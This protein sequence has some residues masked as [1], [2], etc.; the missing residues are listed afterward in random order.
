MPICDE[1]IFFSHSTCSPSVPADM[2]FGS[3]RISHLQFSSRIDSPREA[4]A[5][6]QSPASEVCRDGPAP[7]HAE[8][9][10]HTQRRQSDGEYQGRERDQMQ[11]HPKWKPSWSTSGR[12]VKLLMLTDQRRQEIGGLEWS[13]I[14]AG[15]RLALL[16]GLHSDG[17]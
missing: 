15:K 7:L 13:E 1:S 9:L 6:S 10:E 11:A 4:N 5:A 2:P 16:Q 14:H 17:G 12:I 3:E 8:E